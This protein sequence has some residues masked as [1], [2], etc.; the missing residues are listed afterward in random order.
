MPKWN[1][2]GRQQSEQTLKVAHVK[3][4][5]VIFVRVKTGKYGVNNLE[6][7]HVTRPLWV[8]DW[9]GALR[10][11]ADEVAKMIYRVGP[12]MGLSLQLGYRTK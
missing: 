8:G 3:F 6:D 10:V 11:A 7:K 4:C 2:L 1:Q 12:G 9:R 5:V